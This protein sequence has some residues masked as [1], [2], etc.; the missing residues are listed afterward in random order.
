MYQIT[1]PQSPDNYLIAMVAV[2]KQGHESLP[3]LGTA[4]PRGRGR[5]GRG[6][7]GR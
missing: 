7:G 6:P 4:A 3:T 2:D 5:G 1:I